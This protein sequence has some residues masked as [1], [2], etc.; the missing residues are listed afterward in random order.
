MPAAGPAWA[1]PGAKISEPEAAQIGVE[2][3]IY[4]QG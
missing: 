4:G 3:D 1:Q 2:S